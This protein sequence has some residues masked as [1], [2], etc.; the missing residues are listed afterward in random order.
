MILAERNKTPE[1]VDF[2][3]IMF[4]LVFC[5][6]GFAV[7]YSGSLG[8]ANRIFSDPLYF[9]KK[10]GIN[11]VVGIV[12]M[13][14]LASVNLEAVRKQ[15]PKIV[16]GTL[17]ISLL[18]FV[19]G[20][21]ITKNGATRWI[22]V[23][24]QTFQPSEL[25]KLVVVF[26]LANLFAKK[27]DKLDQPKISIIPAFL[28]SLV[29]VAT[30]YIQND[31]SKSVFIIIIVLVMFYIA[32]V[33]WRWFLRLF[34]CTV[35]LVV[36]MVL[37]KEYRVERL[38]SFFHLNTIR[39][40]GNQLNAAPIAF[41]WRLLGC[42]LG[43]ACGS[44]RASRVQSYFIIAS[45]PRDGLFR[46]VPVISGPPSLFL[47]RGYYISLKCRDRIDCISGFGRTTI[48]LL[49]S[50]LNCGV[51]SGCYRYACRCPFSRRGTSLLITLCLSDSY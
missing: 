29:L 13:I 6:L 8:Y 50:L 32:G 7:L 19:P 46:R 17:I 42:G 48:I 16:L 18:P 39:W 40:A 31:F 36:L 14:L 44:F 43:T 9:V 38:M 47:R 23:G 1:R 25:V 11:L 51:E 35:P 28:T 10:Q 5:G 3:F 2:P 49:Q 45:G 22:G 33:D 41:R 4:I 20:I 26:Y 21:G 15:L 24:S 37:S 12:A 34:F 27:F 30:V